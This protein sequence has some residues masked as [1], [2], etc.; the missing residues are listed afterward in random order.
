M[1]ATKPKDMRADEFL[2][3]TMKSIRRVRNL[4]RRTFLLSSFLGLVL[5]LAGSFGCAPSLFAGRRQTEF[6]RFVSVKRIARTHRRDDSRANQR[7]VRQR[8][9]RRKRSRRADQLELRRR[10]AE[11]DHR[12]RKTDGRRARDDRLRHQ[13]QV[14]F[15]C[16]QPAFPRRTNS[17]RVGAKNR[18]GA[19]KVGNSRD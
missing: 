3:L 9:A 8:S 14:G 19:A 7:R 10:R 17:H 18:L 6:V 1:R 2:P 15:I 16:A 4:P 11:R 5:L 12:R 13:N